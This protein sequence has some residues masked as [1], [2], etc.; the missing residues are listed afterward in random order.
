MTTPPQIPP[1]ISPHRTISYELTRWD[2]FVHW[3][4]VILRNRIL[5]VFVPAALIVDGWLVLAPNFGSQSGSAFLLDTLI[6][7]ISFLG[8]IVFI[9]VVLGLANAFML[10]HRGVVG[11]HILEI[12]EEG[13]VERTD[14]N[15]ALHRWPSICRI[16]SLFGYLYIY[17]SDDNS[18]LVPKRRFPPQEIE[19]FETD[20]R[21]RANLT[22]S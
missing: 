20:L 12:T 6:Y 10:K 15:E 3:M 7:I 9:Q 13:L 18:H 22:N 14:C 19:G 4:T 5:Q 17:V 21:N 11:R 1:A 8:S 2:V 16:V